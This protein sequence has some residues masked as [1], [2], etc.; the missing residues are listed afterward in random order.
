MQIMEK[1][2]WGDHVLECRSIPIRKSWSRYD[3]RGTNTVRYLHGCCMYCTVLYRKDSTY[4]MYSTYFTSKQLYLRTYCMIP[5]PLLSVIRQQ[6]RILRL[7]PSPRTIP[8]FPPVSRGPEGVWGE[9]GSLASWAGPAST[10]NLVHI[11][12]PSSNAIGRSPSTYG[13]RR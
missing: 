6:L 9:D 4:C 2:A 12:Q 8:D 13:V 11:N 10:T 5:L 1:T 3:G 7:S